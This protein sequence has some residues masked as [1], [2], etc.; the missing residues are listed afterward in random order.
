MNMKNPFKEEIISSSHNLNGTTS[1]KATSKMINLVF[2]L[3]IIIPVLAVSA[4]VYGW[5]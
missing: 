4:F 1:V 3:V 5:G 2:G